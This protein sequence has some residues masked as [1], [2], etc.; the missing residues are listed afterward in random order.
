MQPSVD[1]KLKSSYIMEV[2]AMEVEN[3]SFNTSTSRS[4]AIMQEC[5][6]N[7]FN[8]Q[9]NDKVYSTFKGVI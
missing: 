5:L 7:H 8:E 2:Q 6:R 9:L 3:I 1:N 4:D